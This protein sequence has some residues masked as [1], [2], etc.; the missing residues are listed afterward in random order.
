MLNLASGHYQ[1]PVADGSRAES[2]FVTLDGH[3]KF[4]HMPFGLTNTPTVFHRM[5]TVV[6][7]PLHY[8]VAMAY[9]DDKLMPSKDS[10]EGLARLG[11]VH[12]L[13]NVNLT[14]QLK[15]CK[16]LGR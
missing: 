10:D 6:L 13:R 15:K 1:V 5:M 4:L 14:L 8:K 16:F 2:A 12:V 11:R 3:Y 9:M 7:G